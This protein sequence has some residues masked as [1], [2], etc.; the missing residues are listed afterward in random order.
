MMEKLTMMINCFN[1]EIAKV[2]QSEFS[3]KLKMMEGGR[4]RKTQNLLPEI[5][6]ETVF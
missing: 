2:S 3:K 5:N 1:C 4:K 6:N